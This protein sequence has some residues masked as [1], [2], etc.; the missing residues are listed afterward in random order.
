MADFWG[1]CKVWFGGGVRDV[2]V[3][4]LKNKFIPTLFSERT[5]WLPTF[6]IVGRCLAAA[7][8]SGVFAAGS[9]RGYIELSA[10]GRQLILNAPSFGESYR[11]WLVRLVK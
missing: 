2:S 11:P 9:M 1:G 4:T 10:L 8:T 7:G 6:L 5:S 3:K